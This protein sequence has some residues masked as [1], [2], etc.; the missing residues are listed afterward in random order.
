[1]AT[2]SSSRGGWCSATSAQREWRTSRRRS[3]CRAWSSGSC[4][5]AS[6]AGT[7]AASIARSRSRHAGT[8]SGPGSRSR[9]PSEPDE[10]AAEALERGL[11]DRTFG[12]VADPHR[13]LPA[14][15]ERRAGCEADALLREQAPAERG[16]V[17]Q[18]VELREQVERAVGIG[19]GHARQRP[20][21]FGAVVALRPQ[22]LDHPPKLVLAVLERGLS[23]DLRERGGVRDV[24]LVQLPELHADVRARH[25]PADAPPRHAVRLRERLHDVHRVVAIAEAEERRRRRA[26]LV[27]GVVDALVDLVGDEP[28]A[29]PAAE[30]EQPPL[31]VDAG[32]PA[33][34]VRRRREEDEPRPRPGG[35]L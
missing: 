32:D 2:G 10:E 20:Q 26:D 27:A 12:G 25:E 24:E 22:L 15:A 16:R 19:H 17:G 1:M 29:A 3:T 4:P 33:E 13:A 18:A 14:G 5:S 21:R 34:R 30:L 7:A 11:E 9:T 35:G 6:R 23:R 8:T 28:E 31:L